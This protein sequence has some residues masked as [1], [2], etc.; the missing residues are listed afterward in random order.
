MIKSCLRLA[1]KWR[2]MVLHQTVFTK[3][4]IYLDQFQR[5]YSH[6]LKV[7]KMEIHR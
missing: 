7:K 3:E 4:T 6:F 1:N 2:E 5:R